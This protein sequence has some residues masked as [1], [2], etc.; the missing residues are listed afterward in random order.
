MSFKSRRIIVSS[1][2]VFALILLTTFSWGQRGRIY[3]DGHLSLTRLCGDDRPITQSPPL[4]PLRPV[5]DND[6]CA[7]FP[8][9]T[10]VLVLLKT[11][12]SE[13]YKRLPIHFMTILKC[14]PNNF[15]IFSDMA[16]TIAGHT[17]HDSLEHVLGSVKNK[18]PDFEIYHRQKK[19]PVASGECNKN[20][21]VASQGWNLDK[22]KNS[23]MAEIAYR[24]RPQYDWY[25]FI[26]ADTYVSF[27]NLM[28][29]LPNVN[30][31]RPHYIGSI[32][33]SGPF[34]FAHG[35][36]GYL[37][38]RALMKSM[39]SGNPGLGNKYDEGVARHCCG[40]IMWSDIVLKETG[41]TPENMWPAFN[42]RKANTL[43]YSEKQWCQPVITLHKMLAEDIDDMYAFE[44]NFDKS[45]GSLRIKDVFHQFLDPNLRKLQ[46]DWDNGSDDVFYAD[47]QIDVKA[48]KNDEWSQLPDRVKKDDLSDLER[49]AHKSHGDCSKACDS[50]DDCFQYRYLDGV[51]GIGRNIRHGV[52][53][54]R[55]EKDSKRVFSG[56]R[57]DKIR[58]WV[59]DQGECQQPWEWPVKDQ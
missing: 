41:L 39:Q 32:E 29:W 52:A 16:Q 50:M 45:G 31:D 43:S 47:P 13:S 59:K 14:L 8:N 35:G 19:C 28:R 56:W 24:M 30:P 4:P 6:E 27:R 10:N 5:G 37:M 2:A 48:R 12:A 49:A 23:H 21:D 26:D 33:Y 40:D 11:G 17:V 7:H 44:T 36:S 42:G 53:V 57:V 46:A 34:P 15:L 38:S 22:Y 25:F 20:H 1:L 9:T 58:Q 18:H 55:D 51:C 54:K 3:R